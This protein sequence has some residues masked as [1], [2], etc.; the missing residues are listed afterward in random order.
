[1]ADVPTAILGADFYLITT[2]HRICPNTS[3]LTVL[4]LLTFRV[5]C[6]PYCHLA[7]CLPSLILLPNFT[8]VFVNFCNTPKL[9]IPHLIHTSGPPVFLLLSPV[10]ARLINRLIKAKQDFEHMPHFGIIQPPKVVGR[11]H[12]IWFLRNLMIGTHVVII[13]LSTMPPLLIGIHLPTFQISLLF[14]MAKDILNN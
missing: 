6:L 14:S 3:L 1:M 4:P 9:S 2:L 10:S 13:V 8:A 7:L 12:Y 11:H 5:F